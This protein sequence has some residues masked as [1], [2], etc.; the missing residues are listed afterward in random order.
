MAGSL[1]ARECGVALTRLREHRLAP[2]ALEQTVA[3]ASGPLSDALVFTDRFFEMEIARG[4]FDLR[5]DRGVRFWDVVRHDVYYLLWAH[6]S[7]GGLPPRK[8]E[9]GELLPK[10]WLR[11]AVRSL[12]T[13]SMLSK[14]RRSRPEYLFLTTARVTA[15]DATIDPISQPYLDLVAG[16]CFVLE[17]FSR[18][19]RYLRDAA[20]ARGAFVSVPQSKL[21]HAGLAG[22]L[23]EAFA[24]YL[25]LRLDPGAL[26]DMID[27]NLLAYDDQ[28]HYFGRV[29]R[30]HRPTA[31]VMVANGILKGLFT[32]AR[33]LDV[34]VIELQHGLIS[35]LHPYY[36]YPRGPS[37]GELRMHPD[38]LLT[39]ASSWMSQVYFAGVRSVAIG[40]EHY[41]PRAGSGGKPGLLIVSAARYHPVLS[42]AA[43]A[44][45][46]RLPRLPIIYK[47]HPQQ[48]GRAQAIGAELSG[49]PNV[50]V[51]AGARSISDLFTEASAMLCIQSTVV[52]EALQV[53]LR[54]FLLTQDDYQIHEDVFAYVERC[55]DA[56]QV[57]AA[58][59]Q[60]CAARVPTPSFFDEFDAAAALRVLSNPSVS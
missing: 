47:L 30:A 32:A 46:R 55:G 36:S 28:Q 9:R 37:Y 2:A 7:G 21:R 27:D 44:I 57:G 20:A 10:N 40:T 51:H 19:A 6:V 16:R 24:E 4:L 25:D 39:F 13:A 26:N 58:L 22:P 14:V 56:D 23:N 18:T 50:T 54:V 35:R 34:P 48:Y 8:S 29:L 45:A 43:K 49:Y 60:P 52:Y 59:E 38:V 1:L 15:G 31:V 17:T 41:R 53:G 11:N 33:E 42:S 12:R 5:D 3:A